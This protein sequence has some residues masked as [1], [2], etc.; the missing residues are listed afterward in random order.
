MDR[1]STILSPATK[2]LLLALAV[3]L[4]LAWFRP[5]ELNAPADPAEPAGQEVVADAVVAVAANLAADEG[6][7]AGPG[8]RACGRRWFAGRR[9]S[10]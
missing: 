10:R 1:P 8:P 4:I 2:V 3:V 7:L 9:P 6:R 5:A